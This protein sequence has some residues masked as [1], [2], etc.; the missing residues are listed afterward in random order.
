MN[1]F[2]KIGFISHP[3][4]IKGEIRLIS[5][6]ELKKNVFIPGFKVYFTDKYE[7]F[8]ITGYR[9]HKHFHMITLEG[10]NNINQILKYKKEQL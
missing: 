9:P 8:I 1:E 3:H 5:N 10:V 4:G 6:F 7:E 2:V